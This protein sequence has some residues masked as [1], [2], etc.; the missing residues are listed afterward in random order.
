MENKIL[1]LPGFTLRHL[2]LPQF[3]WTFYFAAKSAKNKHTFV[4]YNPKYD[5]YM[6]VNGE[7]DTA[8]AITRQVLTIGYIFG[9]KI[10]H[11]VKK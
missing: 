4:M 7:V 1:Y 5:D 6:Q 2:F 8:I 11:Y 3:W 10:I 9:Q